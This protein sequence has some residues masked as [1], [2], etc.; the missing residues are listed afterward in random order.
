MSDSI[1]YVCFCVLL[2]LNYIFTLTYVQS[3]SDNKRKLRVLVESALDSRSS[4]TDD[5][6]IFIFSQT[7]P[8]KAL[9]RGASRSLTEY[10]CALLDIVQLHFPNM[11]GSRYL[12]MTDHR[13]AYRNTFLYVKSTSERLVVGIVA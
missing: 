5:E 12:H 7:E 1:L 6:R 2:V 3:H 9:V 10:E 8:R 4:G 13:G 11:R